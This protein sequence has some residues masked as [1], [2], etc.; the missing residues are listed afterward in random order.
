MALVPG[1]LLIGAAIAT[2]RLE[3]VGMISAAA[4]LIYIVVA[5]P[6]PHLTAV[7]I[8][9]TFVDSSLTPTLLSFGDVN[10]GL[11]EV[12]LAVI[13]VAGLLRGRRIPEYDIY[14][15]TLLFIGWGVF[16]FYGGFPSANIAFLK[17]AEPLIISLAIARIAPVNFDVWRVV[18]WVAVF[19]VITA[20]LF[21]PNLLIRWNAVVGQPNQYGLVSAVLLVLALSLP[22]SR[23]RTFQVVIA[24]VGMLTAA[25]ITSSLAATAGVLAAG[26]WTPRSQQ[27]RRALSPA[28]LITV[29]P[30]VFIVVSV[31]RPDLLLTLSIHSGQAFAIVPLLTVI[32]PIFGGGWTFSSAYVTA[33]GFRL[34][35]IHNVYLQ[36]LADLGLIGIGFFVGL[37]VTT[38]RVCTDVR[39]RAVLVVL[40]IWQNSAGAFPGSPW[41]VLGA[42]LLAARLEHVR[43]LLSARTPLAA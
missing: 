5:L 26:L 9:V 43:R 19:T 24:L 1:C 3:L 30:V 6:P 15:W 31:L 22:P 17:L 7:A 23:S 40:A 27:A 32:N 14:W 10:V 41:G 39:T 34:L 18:R 20:P 28:A 12:F 29:I 38:F 37:L 8:A 13:G 33:Q 2:H 42:V 11:G 35:S 16:R 21:T 36:L 4:V 25:S